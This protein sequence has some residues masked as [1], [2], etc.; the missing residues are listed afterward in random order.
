MLGTARQTYSVVGLEPSTHRVRFELDVRELTGDR[1][2]LVLPVW[3]PGAYEIVESSREVRE[4]SARRGDDGRPLALERV[5][6]NRWRIDT[7]GA[8][9]VRVAWTSYAHVMADDG[10]DLTDEHLFLN[11]PRCLPWIEGR[12]GEPL[13]IALHLPAGWS[14]HAE[15]PRVGESPPCFRAESYE[16]LVDAPIDCGTPQVVELRPAGIPHHLVI[17]GGPSNLEL[18]RVEADIARIVEEQIRYF[19]DSPLRSFTFFLHLH[20]RR[21]GGLEHANSTSLVV[22]RNSFRPPEEYDR[23]LTL[24][25]HEYFHLYNVKRIRPKVLGP[26]DFDREVYSKMLWWMEGTTDYV[27][28]LLVRRAGLFTPERYLEKLAENARLY[29]TTPGRAVKSLEESSQATWVD[30]YR[31]YEESRNQSISYYVKGHLVSAALDLEIRHRTENRRSLDSVFRYLWKEYGR[32]GRG[33]EEDEIFSS[34]ERA[35]E[36]ELSD[37]FERYVRGTAELDLGAVAA[38]AGLTFGPAPRPP[39][40]GSA[41][42]FL[43]VEY[44]NEG[45]RVRVREVLDHTP[46]RRAGI[47]PGDEIIAL[48]GAK[49]VFEQFPEAMKRFPAGSAV[50]LAFFRRGLLT[51]RTVTT[52]VAPPAKYVFRPMADA[53]PAARAIYA[54]WLG[55]TWEAPGA[56]TGAP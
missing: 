43:G 38:R 40:D 18:H 47:S 10:F 44:A 48:D 39:G 1:L 49:V 14:A 56:P 19:G 4:M 51:R 41:P 3:S 13:E 46:A 32:P 37:F 24:V 2:E 31:P 35:T 21:D 26:F 9:E 53:S 15:L 6:K 36:L 5:R 50:E 42:G 45:G 23:F 7:G 30:L 55:A 11:A 8:S 12:A 29:L 25:A 16:A 22:E 28:H 20:D 34:I 54:S 33:L 52:A 17:C 27:A